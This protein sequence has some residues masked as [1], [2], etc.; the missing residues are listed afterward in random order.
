MTYTAFLLLTSSKSTLHA[1]S[2]H[3]FI[4]FRPIRFPLVTIFKNIQNQVNIIR[5]ILYPS[6]ILFPLRIRKITEKS[7]NGNTIKGRKMERQ[8]QRHDSHPHIKES[9]QPK[10]HDSHS[11]V[12]SNRSAC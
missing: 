9:S 4:I 6:H 1:C 2:T 7:Y 8:M 5:K 12:S 10:P 3:K 11:F